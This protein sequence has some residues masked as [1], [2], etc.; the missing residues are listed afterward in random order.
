MK[1]YKRNAFT[2]IELLAVVVLVALL[3]AAV[4]VSHSGVTGV[5]GVDD[6]VEQVGAFDRLTRDMARARA[7]A[8]V[9]VFDLDAQRIRRVSR[10]TGKSFGHELSLGE[11]C[12]LERLHTGDRQQFGGVAE[13]R[14]SRQGFCPSY[15][16]NLRHS[17]GTTWMV[18][19][20]LS[21]Q[22]VRIS[23]EQ[24]LHQILSSTRNDA[25]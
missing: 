24:Q 1:P 18:V 13:V 14:V 4:S 9:M 10:A 2:L 19:L 23:D 17:G 25:R 20:G 12:R 3:A 11:H 16:L 15:A 22:V 7:D 5:G 21:G 6:A 8:L